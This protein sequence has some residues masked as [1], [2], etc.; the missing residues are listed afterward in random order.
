M[1]EPLDSFVGDPSPVF[2][3]VSLASPKDVPLSLVGLVLGAA[4]GLEVAVVGALVPFELE[5]PGAELVTV[6]VELGL[7]TAEVE[8]GAVDELTPPDGE[9][10]AGA[11]LPGPVVPH[12]VSRPTARVWTAP[13]RAVTPAQLIDTGITENRITSTSIGD[14]RADAASPSDRVYATFLGHRG[15]VFVTRTTL[16]NCTQTRPHD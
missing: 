5:L 14:I 12:A 4:L 15:G 8:F 10:S 13:R 9:E 1:S 6:L 16:G 2:C 3:E 11:G 7:G